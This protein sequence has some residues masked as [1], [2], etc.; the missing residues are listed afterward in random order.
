MT[1]A[2]EELEQLAEECEVCAL[3]HDESIDNHLITCP[4]CSDHVDKAHEIA[5]MIEHMKQI[6]RDDEEMRKE[7]LVHDVEDFLAMS[8]EERKDAMSD[9]FDNIADLN[10]AERTVI[11]KTRTDIMTSLPK[12]ERDRMIASAREIYSSYDVNRRISEEQAILAA[13]ED[14]NPLK[15]TMVRRMYKRMM[16]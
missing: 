13:T 16:R 10:E 1:T 11:V 7:V 3:E 8:D 15:R 2:R 5:H 14:Y 9:M 12:E 4:S 6:S